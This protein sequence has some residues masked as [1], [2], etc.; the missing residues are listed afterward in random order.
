[1]IEQLKKIFK[2]AEQ[3]GLP[4]PPKT[5]SNP[6]L[7]QR[8]TYGAHMYRSV[9][10]N[11]T[12]VFL[13][14]VRGIRKEIVD[15]DGR[16]LN[17]PGIIQ[18]EWWLADLTTKSYLTPCVRFRTEFSQETDGRFRM[19]WQ[20]QPDGR[21]WADADGFGMENDLEIRLYTHIDLNGSFT[22]PFRIYSLGSKNYYL[23]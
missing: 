13:D 5:M 2:K 19:V 23:S 10:E 15:N 17:F 4:S 11:V 22:G 3:Q 14:D 7:S 1:M 6:R 21:Y 12:V 8:Y 16:I 9:E 18:E 20:I